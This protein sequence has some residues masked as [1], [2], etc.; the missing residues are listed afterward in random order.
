M[1]CLNIQKSIHTV[2]S[3]KG[4]EDGSIPECDAY[5]ITEVSKA[6][7]I[8]LVKSAVI[9]VLT[10]NKLKELICTDKTPYRKQCAHE[11]WNTGLSE[12]MQD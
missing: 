1:P 2:E 3:S 9:Q 11:L 12:V 7:G 4:N 5:F 10:I 8:D 6:M